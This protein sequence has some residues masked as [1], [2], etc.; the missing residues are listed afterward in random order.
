MEI[1]QELLK[2]LFRYD[3]ETG[4]LFYKERL[5]HLFRTPKDCVVWNKRFK[6]KKAKSETHINGESFL[7]AYV[8]GKSL[9][10]HRLI[11]LLV[12]GESPKY[13]THKNGNT[14]DNRFCNLVV[15]E[16][17]RDFSNKLLNLKAGIKGV[18]WD[19][20]G[21]RWIVSFRSKTIGTCKNHLDA[22][23]MRKSAENNS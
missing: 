3:P 9:L 21:Q 13:L 18:Y 7:R 23:S 16:K 1:T 8:D 11:Y 10:Q 4:D 12:T 22:I 20:T 5:Q 17:K 19:N 2:Q 6:G 15:S 14:L